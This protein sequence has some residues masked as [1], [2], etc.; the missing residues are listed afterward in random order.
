M[1]RDWIDDPCPV[2]MWW[3]LLCVLAAGVIAAVGIAGLLAAAN[4]AGAFD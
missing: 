4:S 1:S 2:S 3:G